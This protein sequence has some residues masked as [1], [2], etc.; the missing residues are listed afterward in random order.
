VLA[1]MKY[2]LAPKGTHFFCHPQGPRSTMPRECPS[3]CGLAVSRR[4]HRSRMGRTGSGRRGK[5]SGQRDGE[6]G[7]TKGDA[8]RP[9]VSRGKRLG[10]C[11]RG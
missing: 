11:S 7:L 1:G 4:A 3:Q 5:G 6:G 9:R 8:Q 10:E 2:L